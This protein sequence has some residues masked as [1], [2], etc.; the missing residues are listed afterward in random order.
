MLRM[1]W[2]GDRGVGFQRRPIS[3]GKRDCVA[4][5]VAAPRLS[6]IFH[7]TRRSRAGLTAL[8]PLRGWFDR[9]SGGLSHRKILRPVARQ[10]LKPGASVVTKIGQSVYSLLTNR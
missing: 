10:S 3:L 8:P 5:G 7:F 4:T 2:W 6:S 9:L 1:D